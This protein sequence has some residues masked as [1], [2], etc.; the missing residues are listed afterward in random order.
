MVTAKKRRI[1]HGMAND[2]VETFAQPKPEKSPFKIRSVPLRVRQLISVSYAGQPIEEGAIVRVVPA[3]D[4]DESCVEEARRYALDQG[5]VAVKVERVQRRA[6]AAPEA[7][8]EGEGVLM[9]F[10]MDRRGAVLSEVEKVP[11]EARDAVGKIVADVVGR[12]L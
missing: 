3:P 5:A 6:L 1:V 8:E 9:G 2:H 11:E 4:A 7:Q 12:I 10:R